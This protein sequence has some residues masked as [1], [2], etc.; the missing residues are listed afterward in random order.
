MLRRGNNS[1]TF[2]FARSPTTRDY[3]AAIDRRRRKTRLGSHRVREKA[4][5]PGSIRKFE[6]SYLAAWGV[7]VIATFLGWN[8]D[9][10]MASAAG[11]GLGMG[12]IAG[13]LALGMVIP[14]LLCYFASR[15]RSNIARWIIVALFA[16]QALWMLRSLFTVSFTPGVVGALGIIAFVL[17]AVAV[18]FL[19]GTEARSWFAKKAAEPA[20]AAD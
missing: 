12:V 3:P 8:S 7:G 10:I 17:R 1:E 11:R 2:W 5:Q 18:R 15:R 19:F 4:M 14:L 6:I 20:P 13:T 16:V 9:A